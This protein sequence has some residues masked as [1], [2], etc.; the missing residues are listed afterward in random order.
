MRRKVMMLSGM[1]PPAAGGLERAAQITAR[2]LV[3]RGH[4]VAVVTL[5]RRDAPAY[6]VDAGV[7][8]HRIA[9]WNRFLDRFYENPD[10]AFA[11]PVPDPGAVRRIR[12]IARDFRPDVL[13]AHDWILYSATAASSAPLVVSLHDHGLVCVKRTYLRDGDICDGPAFAKCVR[14]G[15]EQYGPLKS[16]ALT[17]GLF[18]TGRQRRRVTRYL[19]VSDAVRD[20]AIAHSGLPSSRFQTMASPI[21]DDLASLASSTPPPPW[22]PDA[23]YVLYAGALAPHKG[24]TVLLEALAAMERA[25]KLLILGIRHDDDEIALPPEATLIE[26]ASRAEIMAAYR[27]AACTVVPSI[28][29][30]PLANVARE[31]LLCGSPVVASAVGGLPEIVTHEQDGLLVP[32]RDPAA[33]AAALTRLLDEP[34]TRAAMREAGQRGARRFTASVVADQLEAAYEDVLAARASA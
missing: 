8:V 32:P 23:D 16:V 1:Y 3:A 34:Q 17:A 10:R 9:G 27:H 12:E 24:L 22:L 30:E 4:E 15:V 26:G 29:P 19:P 28:W 25:P 21:E 2:T 5:A 6:E 13:H 18:G 33:L 20:I 14:S 7:E 11:P 31:A